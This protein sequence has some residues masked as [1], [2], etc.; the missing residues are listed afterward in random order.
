MYV[1]EMTDSVKNAT[2]ITNKRRKIQIKYNKK[3]GIVPK[4]TKGHLRIKK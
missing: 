2:A 4:T 1:D 3:H